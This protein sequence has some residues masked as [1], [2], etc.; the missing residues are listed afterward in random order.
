MEFLALPCIGFLIGVIIISLGGGGGG[1][2]VGILTAFFDV[3]PAVAAAT[4]LATIIPTTTIGSVS[5]WREGNINGRFGGIMMVGAMLG[6]VI[7]S[8]FSGFMPQYVYTKLTGGL[9]LILSGQMLM[10]ILKQRKQQRSEGKKEDTGRC[11][12]TMKN[13]CTATFYGFLGGIMSG[14]V[15]LSGTGPIIAGL[16]ILGCGA[17]ETV[18]TSVFVLVGISI[19]GFSMH[20][21]MGDVDWP[22]VGQLVIGTMSGA[23]LS[24]LILK[25]MDKAKME[26]VLPPIL[27]VM[28]FVMGI[29]VFMK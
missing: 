28:V 10:S 26:N 18:G 25:K 4:S 27:M 12:I 6:A 2:Y 3:P 14:L 17:L 16:T 21:G 20:L 22:L 7:G 13:V 15:G 23:F 19:A 29:I 9:L 1:F 24:P 11:G 8:Y 5:H